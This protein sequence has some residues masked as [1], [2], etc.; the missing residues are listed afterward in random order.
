M[1]ATIPTTPTSPSAVALELTVGAGE[2]F[3]AAYW[4]WKR[5]E[6]AVEPAPEAFGIHPQYAEVLARQIHLEFEAQVKARA[7]A[8]QPRRGA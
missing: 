6:I 1:N 8:Q 2:R 4:Q 5:R 3:S 7:L